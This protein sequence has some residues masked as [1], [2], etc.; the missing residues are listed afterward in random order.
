MKRR[1]FKPEPPTPVYDMAD[2]ID[3]GARLFGSNP[4]QFYRVIEQLRRLVEMG[5]LMGASDLETLGRGQNIW[6]QRHRWGQ[7]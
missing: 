2:L 5:E 7:A 6:K 3:L 4:R 1:A